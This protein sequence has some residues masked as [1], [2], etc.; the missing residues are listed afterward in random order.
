M[1]LLATVEFGQLLDYRL[2]DENVG[3]QS[4]AFRVGRELTFV[5]SRNLCPSR[6]RMQPSSNQDGTKRILQPG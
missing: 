2:T 6:Y 1:A 4:T 3:K 5:F